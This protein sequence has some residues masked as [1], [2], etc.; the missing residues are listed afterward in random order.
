MLF[1]YRNLPTRSMKG[2]TPDVSESTVEQS[3]GNLAREPKVRL[4]PGQYARERQTDKSTCP[5][6]GAKYGL[7]SGGLYA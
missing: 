4:Q 5:E 2:T 1:D 3:P 7:I 6:R